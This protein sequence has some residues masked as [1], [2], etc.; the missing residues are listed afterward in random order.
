M[1]VGG[2]GFRVDGRAEPLLVEPR[3]EYLKQGFEEP[4]VRRPLKPV[5]E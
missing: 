3:V 1:G 2:W 5:K 4:E